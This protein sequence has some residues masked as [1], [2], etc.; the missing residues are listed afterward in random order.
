MNQSD[1]GTYP[2]S[3][4]ISRTGFT[5]YM[6]TLVNL[7]APSEAAQDHNLASGGWTPGNYKIYKGYFLLGSDNGGSSEWGVPS[8]AVG[9]CRRSILDVHGDWRDVQP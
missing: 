7:E 9:N 3:M 4:L 1:S 2:S 5:S 6:D 8:S